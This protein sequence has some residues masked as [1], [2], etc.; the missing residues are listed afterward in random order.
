MMTG[1]RALY[2]AAVFCHRTGD[3]RS[4]AASISLLAYFRRRCVAGTVRYGFWVALVAAGF[5][6]LAVCKVDSFPR[7]ALGGKN[8]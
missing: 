2:L 6:V 7:R 4:A 3:S 5:I 1:Y 8:I